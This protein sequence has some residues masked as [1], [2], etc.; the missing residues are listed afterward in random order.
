MLPSPAESGPDRRGAGGHSAADSGLMAAP[1]VDAFDSAGSIA[2][3]S[4]RAGG[5]FARALP[6]DP[7]CAG[8]A[9]SFFREAVAGIG[10]PGDLVH[11]GVTM[12]NELAANTLHA[13][14]NVEISGA[15][16]GPGPRRPAGRG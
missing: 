9:R 14:G 16:Q 13:Q 1:V 10:L 4:V 15:S 5:C 2:E 11:D 8:A 3:A 7:T 12:A 6:L